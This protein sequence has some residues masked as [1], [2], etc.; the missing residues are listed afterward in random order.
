MLCATSVPA[1]LV[2]VAIPPSPLGWP[3]RGGQSG[4]PSW[5]HA[6][7][8]MRLFVGGIPY[9]TTE[10]ELETLFSNHGSVS[11]VNLVRERE[12]DRPR[13]F[14]FVDMPNDEEA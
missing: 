10:A 3:G 1:L 12:T 8:R 6:R 11:S 13:G 14:G 2:P 7:C 4:C 5:M 9:A